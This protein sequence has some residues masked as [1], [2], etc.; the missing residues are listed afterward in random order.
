MYIT[1][2]P[3]NIRVI[4]K[5]YTRIHLSRLAQLLDLSGAEAEESLSSL[6]VS[7]TVSA[8]ID[9]CR[10]YQQLKNEEIINL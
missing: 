7:H 1:T 2:D 4:A 3:Q 10:L 5:Y 6:V 8:K 9:R